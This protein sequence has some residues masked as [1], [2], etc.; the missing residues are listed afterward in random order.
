MSQRLLTAQRA[1]R[2]AGKVL[3]AK[4]HDRRDIR[5]KGKRD[6][7]TDADYAADR[8]IK[9]IVL[10]R[11]PNDKFVSEEGDAE[12]HK[13]LWAQ[14]DAS[15]GVALW[16]VDPLDGTTN[17]AHT[18]Y[19]F[20]TSIALYQ[21]GASPNRRRVR[22]DEPRTVFCRTRTRRVLE[23][24]ADSRQR[25]PFARRCGV[26]RGMGARAASP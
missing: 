11:F 16:V 23:R 18:L 9:Q 6:I 14:A 26:R 1:A 5:Y 15:D 2:A 20:C 10:S 7:V 12:E 25:D 22:S 13:R 19:A 3:A 8:T 17:Y 24:Q 21:A 4:L